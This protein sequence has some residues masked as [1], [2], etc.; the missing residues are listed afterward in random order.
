MQ[1]GKNDTIKIKDRGFVWWDKSC[2]PHI[3]PCQV[4][5]GCLWATGKIHG[6]FKQKT[7]IITGTL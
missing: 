2:L 4:K 5:S 6:E 7:D 1:N 3:V